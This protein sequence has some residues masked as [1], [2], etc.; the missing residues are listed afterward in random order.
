MFVLQASV[1]RGEGQVV[2][3]TDKLQFVGEWLGQEYML[4]F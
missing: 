4:I 1:Y 2:V 3:H